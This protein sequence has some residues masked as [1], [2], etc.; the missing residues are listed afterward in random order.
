[1]S[2]ETPPVEQAAEEAPIATVKPHGPLGRI[3]FALLAALVVLVVVVLGL[4]DTGMGHRFVT[5]RIAAL[6]PANGLRYSIGRIEGSIYGR[7]TLIDVRV[8]DT[9]GVF[10]AAPR[11]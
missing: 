6:R 4:I 9:R 7:A 11:A 3:V 5:D 10:F 2:D 8:R 1:M